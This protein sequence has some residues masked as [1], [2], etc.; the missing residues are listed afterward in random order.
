MEA[1]GGPVIRNKDQ[2]GKWFERVVDPGNETDEY[3]LIL[4][5]T[6]NPVGEIRFHRLNLETMN[7]ELNI[8]VVF[9]HRGNGFAKQ[10]LISFLDYFFNEYGGLFIIDR[11]AINNCSGKKFLLDFGF[12]LDSQSSDYF[13]LQITRGDYNS[14]YQI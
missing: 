9:K 8:K 1:V 11:V 3:R 7:A 12:T 6:G 14:K 2:I 13:L 10:A 5:Q 4:D